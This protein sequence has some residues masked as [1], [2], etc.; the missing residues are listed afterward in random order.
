VERLAEGG[1]ALGARASAAMAS[2]EP[3]ARL[4]RFRREVEAALP[5]RAVQVL[6]FGSRVRGKA[7]EDSDHD[8]A[9]LLR[10]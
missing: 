9:V 2:P 5:G 1:L 3:A 7:R 6:L 10:G 4:R 8:V